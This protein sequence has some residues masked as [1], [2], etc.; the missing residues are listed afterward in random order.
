[1]GRREAHKAATR[2]AL[3][4][5]AD[6][7]FAERGF[8]KTTVRDIVEAAGVT[9]RTFFRYFAGKQELILDDALAWVDVLRQLIVERPPSEDPVT[10]VRRAVLELIPSVQ[11]SS[12]RSPWWLF[13]EGPPA[14]HVTDRAI[15]PAVLRVERGLA[16]A[17]GERLRQWGQRYPMDVELLAQLSART[18]FGL[19]R[20]VL[21]WRHQ[22]EEEGRP[23]PELPTLII[24]A[25][26]T[27]HI[28]VA[29]TR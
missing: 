26:S 28:P 23:L 4:E 18:V 22:L 29:P 7:L 15:A 21:L 19:L 14:D 8:E 1:M 10:A 11:L 25:F 27:L 20:T 3:Q 2:Q 17:I 24:Q 5:A 12:R 13:S 16:V 9:E 6:R